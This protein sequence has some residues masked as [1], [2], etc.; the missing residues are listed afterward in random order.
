MRTLRGAAETGIGLAWWALAYA[1]GAALLLALVLLPLGLAI[2]TSLIVDG[3]APAAALGVGI[4]LSFLLDV[5]PWSGEGRWS[6]PLVALAASASWAGWTALRGYPGVA[7]LAVS[8]GVAVAC[9][10]VRVGV[11]RLMARGRRDVA[12]A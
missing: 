11:R 10:A 1:W 3:L 6:L 4:A 7:A 8:V 12:S 5:P 2:G 9:W